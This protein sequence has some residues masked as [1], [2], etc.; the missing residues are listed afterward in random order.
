ML[1]YT[2]DLKLFWSQKLNFCFWHAAENKVT[3]E[4]RVKN[5]IKMNF[6]AKVINSIALTKVGVE[7]EPGKA[8]GAGLLCNSTWNQHWRQAPKDSSKTSEEFQ[9]G[10]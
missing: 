7:E 10:I 4:F 2:W 6:S 8:L 9:Q 5:G 1:A 3:A